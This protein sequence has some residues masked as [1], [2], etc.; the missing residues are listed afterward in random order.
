MS[1]KNTSTSGTG[2]LNMVLDKSL[3]FIKWFIGT[4]IPKVLTFIWDQSFSLSGFIL[5]AIEV[6][7][8]AAIPAL[9]RKGLKN[10]FSTIIFIILLALL[11]FLINRFL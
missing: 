10:L 2:L 6:K 9:K 5:E 4:L 8:G 7:R 3:Q 1:Q 11:V